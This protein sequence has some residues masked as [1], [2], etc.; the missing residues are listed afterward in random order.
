M[1]RLAATTAKTLAAPGSNPV[2]AFFVGN[3][4]IANRKNEVKSLRDAGI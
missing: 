4:V 3:P 2:V 1:P